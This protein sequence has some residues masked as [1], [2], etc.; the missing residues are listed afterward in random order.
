MVNSMTKSLK[1]LFQI[2]CAIVTV[3]MPTLLLGQDADLVLQHGKILT[4]N[5]ENQIVSAIAVRGQ[6]HICG[7]SFP[8]LRFPPKR[9]KRRCKMFI[10][11]TMPSESPASSSEPG[12]SMTFF[13]TENCSLVVLSMNETVPPWLR[14]CDQ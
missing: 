11:I 13:C 9:S 4:M 2:A 14:R 5:A 8:N 3:G 6:V 10:S 7:R 12:A 1:N